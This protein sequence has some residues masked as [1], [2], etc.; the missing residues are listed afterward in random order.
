MK[1]CRRLLC[2]MPDIV[3]LFYLCLEQMNKWRTFHA[4]GE[5]FNDGLGVIL[6]AD[7]VTQR[8]FSSVD[9]RHNIVRLV[10]ADESTALHPRHIFRVGARQP[11]EDKNI[12]IDLNP[13]I[14]SSRNQR[15]KL[16]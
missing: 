10:G 4:A 2:F 8:R 12:Q 13:V 16:K 11:T 7:P 5:P 3:C 6:G 9:A 1:A 14:K 15:N